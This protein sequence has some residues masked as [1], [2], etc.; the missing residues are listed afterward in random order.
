M[1]AKRELSW[2]PT[3]RPSIGMRAG[4]LK[5]IEAAF[6]KLYAKGGA[7]AASSSAALE[8]GIQKMPRN[9]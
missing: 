7:A 3:P 2:S 1:R 6:E 8:D 4:N 5:A 9:Y